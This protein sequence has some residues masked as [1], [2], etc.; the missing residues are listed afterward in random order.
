MTEDREIVRIAVR[1]LVE[2]TLRSG[3]LVIDQWE[4][5][6]PA[7]AIRAHRKVQSLRPDGYQ[8]EYTL[9]QRIRLN[10][11]EVS[12]EGRID[13][14]MVEDGRMVVEEIKTTRKNLAEIERTQNPLHWAQAQVYT[15]M[16]SR[17][18]GTADGIETQ[19]T[20]YQLDSG[21]VLELRRAFPPDELEELFLGLLTR[22]LDRFR[23]LREWRA[24]RDRS[25]ET[26]PFP[27]TE[28]RPGQR[29]LAV[30]IY[31]AVRD[32]RQ[33]LVQAPTGIGKTMGSLYP[34]LKA[35]GESG[36]GKLL[37]LTA[38][39]TGQ[40]VAEKAV[41]E[42]RGSGLKLRSVQLTAKEKTCFNPERACNGEECDYARGYYDRVEAALE[43]VCSAELM[44]RSV[45]ESVAARHRVCPFELALD[46]LN[47][48][49]L[50]ICDY[51]YAFD[52]R[53]FLRRV[54]LDS[55]APVSLIVDEAHNLVDRAREMFSAALT[56]S[57]VAFLRREVRKRKHHAVEKAL[58][59]L[60]AWMLRQRDA[61]RDA[62]GRTVDTNQ[63]IDLL[64]LLK[65]YLR[66]AEPFLREL[67]PAAREYR[68]HLLEFQFQVH[69]FLRTTEFWGEGY[70]THCVADGDDLMIKLVCLDPA[71][72]LRKQMARCT[73]AVFLSATLSPVDY[74][75]KLF[76][77]NDAAE[78]LRCPPPFPS[79]NLQV[80]VA[81][82]VSTFYRR[83]Q[84]TRGEVADLIRAFVG[85]RPGN[86]LVY[87]P[88][89]EYL[90]S[91]RELVVQSG[92][93][94]F[95]V[96]VQEPGMDED[97]RR[98]FLAR[99]EEGSSEGTL[100][101]LAV[102][103]GIFGE[104]IDLVGERL[105]GAA[106][107]GVGLPGLS[108]ERDMIRDYY[109][110]KGSRGFDFA[111]AVPGITRVLQAAGRVIRTERDRGTILLIDQR[112]SQYS[113]RRLLPSEWTPVRVRNCRELT[114][115]I[116]FFWD[117]EEGRL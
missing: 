58:G 28:F 79:Q 36:A 81:D 96:I 51:N 99:Y 68:E 25:L 41:E 80:I 117:G 115:V 113:Y 94:N 44:N 18:R 90:D 110:G 85:A 97:S 93:R 105:T 61:C 33:L 21:E 40:T 104:A 76:G 72:P 88:S 106:I 6:D 55:E 49:D 50:V 74:Y 98:Q 54:L 19:L 111:Y 31:R 86:Y 39:T 30:G 100:V 63:P 22:F 3:D 84:E 52:P 56:R 109:D 16:L 62:G 15:C 8:A 42:L 32:Q 92:V 57:G 69:R 67:D 60:A 34:A 95:E 82:Y 13:G 70:R 35:L 7:E 29:R 27:Y 116:E 24:V 71:K 78:A 65:G 87:F 20:Y 4:P 45:L 89:F 91:V 108:P 38:R 47:R 102:L 73:S 107:V 83:R 26:L 11:T 10:G 23:E 9:R 43:E 53:A 5:I 66:V 112:F 77:C 17:E 2:G 48:A 101:G 59:K 103:G 14:L 75:R 1:A 64:P 12:V 114:E 46:A 37:F